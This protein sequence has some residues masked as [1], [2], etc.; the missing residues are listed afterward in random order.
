ML[1]D[2]FIRALV[3]GVG[4]AIVA[5]PL[6]CFIVWRRLA[7]FGDTLSHGALL[8]VAF[9]LLM[10][11]NITLAVFAVSASIA[12]TLLILQKQAIVS[13][14]S[15]LGLL[16]H[17]ALHFNLKFSP[18]NFLAFSFDCTLALHLHPS[19]SFT[20]SPPGQPPP[21]CAL[22]WSDDVCIG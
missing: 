6:G 2:F 10:D 7:Y 18:I 12:V 5:G 17:S 20:F 13:S 14:D 11:T 4:V 3:A 8:G 22:L 16:S 9:A 21:H 15:L 1:D 19:F